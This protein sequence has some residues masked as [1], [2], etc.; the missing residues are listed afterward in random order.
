MKP[1]DIRNVNFDQL[2][3]GLAA[4]RADVWRAWIVHGPCS[5]RDLSELAH[6]DILS[7]RPRTTE[8]YQCGLVMLVDYMPGGAGICG[9]GVYQARTAAEWESWASEQRG[10]AVSKQLQM[11]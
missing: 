5:T 1:I 6:L 10:A 11:I 9:E 8:L 2:V 4:K 3:A 7:L